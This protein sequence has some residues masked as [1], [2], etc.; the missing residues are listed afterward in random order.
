LKISPLK[1]SPP[2]PHTHM[3]SEREIF[4]FGYHCEQIIEKQTK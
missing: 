4:I 2:P 3:Y 1:I